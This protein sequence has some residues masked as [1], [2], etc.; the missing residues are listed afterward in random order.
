[1]RTHAGTF[2]EPA[3]EGCESATFVGSP[4]EQ[5]AVTHTFEWT[6]PAEDGTECAVVS[7]AQSSGPNVAYRTGTVRFAPFF[8][9]FGCNPRYRT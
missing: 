4:D 1:M 3:K 6:A 8:F 9:V 7:T 2:A 5:P